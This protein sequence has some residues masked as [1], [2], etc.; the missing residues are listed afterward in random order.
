MGHERDLKKCDAELDLL[1]TVHKLQR[2]RRASNVNAV[3]E[4]N[5]L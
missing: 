2:N 3:P 5:V 1:G 4:T